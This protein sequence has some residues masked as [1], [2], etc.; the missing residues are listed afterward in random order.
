MRHMTRFSF[1]KLKGRQVQ[2]VTHKEGSLRKPPEIQARW[3]SF[4]E[5]GC[6]DEIFGLRR[7]DV[8]NHFDS[9]GGLQV[10]QNIACVHSFKGLGAD[11]CRASTN[12]TA[13]RKRPALGAVPATED[14]DGVMTESFLIQ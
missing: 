12:S 13:L 10:L 9:I 1:A 2:V 7:K 8:A 5:E 4:I 6:R 14:F 11:L 3:C